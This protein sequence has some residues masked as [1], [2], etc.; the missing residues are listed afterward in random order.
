TTTTANNSTGITYSLDATTVAF[1]GNSINSSTGAVT[2]AAGWSGTT[3]ITASAAGCNGPATTTHVVTISVAPSISVQPS[4]NAVCSGSTAAF[5]VTASGSPTYAW[6]KRGSGWG[7]SGAWTSFVGSGQAI[8]SSLGNNNGDTGSAID[9]SGNAWRLP[10][11]NEA[12]RSLG[13]QTLAVGQV[14]N[15]DFDNGN[16]ANGVS[17]GFSIRNASDQNLFEFYFT[18][19]G[20][21]YVIGAGSQ[22]GTLPTFT[23]LGLN[24]KFTLTSSSTYSVFIT[25]YS[26]SSTYTITG[27]LSS[28]GGGQAI[29]KVRLWNY[30]GSPGGNA[31]AY[32]NNLSFGTSGTTSLYDDNASNYTTWVTS[33]NKG[34]GPLA[35]G[36]TGTGSTVSNA[37]TASLSIA[38]V[39]ASDVA[40]YDV[41][42]YNS[43]GGATS[44]AAALTLNTAPSISASSADQSVC[45]GANPTYSVTATGTALTYQWRKNG[46]AINDGATGNGSTYGGTSTATL[47]ITGAVAADAALSGA[48]FDCVVSGTC[49]P[50]ATSTRRALTINSTVTIN[51]FSPTTSTR[52]QG[53]GTVTTTTTANN[54]TGITYSL[55]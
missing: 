20:S 42:V 46:V 26:D 12:V 19:G 49:T 44:T 10:I 23:R 32:Y 9:V 17:V 55:D 11:N 53:A 54:S 47:T 41:V 4:A 7:T 14:I 18:G 5:T 33:D 21:N 27:N 31:D 43:C 45:S 29:T 50:T 2:Y 13:G 48:G 22:S 24:I 36:A 3:T 8:A 6:R 38:T 30:A 39:G 37:T 52:C 28:P 34:Q 25:R 51:A 1:S 40:S 15:L 16:V 35:N